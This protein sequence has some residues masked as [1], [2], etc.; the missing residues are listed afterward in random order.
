[1]YFLVDHKESFICAFRSNW[2]FDFLVL[3]CHLNFLVGQSHE[4]SAG[5]TSLNGQKGFGTNC[6]SPDS[7]N[8]YPL[9]MG[10]GWWSRHK[11][12][13]FGVISFPWCTYNFSFHLLPRNEI[14]FSNIWNF[15]HYISFIKSSTITSR[16]QPK[17]MQLVIHHWSQSLW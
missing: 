6:Q 13:I 8:S 9:E 16:L 2:H 11:D 1:M 7:Y 10:P 15:R 12:N 5:Q 17:R 3:Y 4:L 14:L